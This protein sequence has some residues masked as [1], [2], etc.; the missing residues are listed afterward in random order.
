[1]KLNKAQHIHECSYEYQLTVWLDIK[2]QTHNPPYTQK[3]P[4][5]SEVGGRDYCIEGAETG[6]IVFEHEYILE[7]EQAE[8]IMNT[9]RL[10]YY[11]VTAIKVIFYILVVLIHT[12]LLLLFGGG[13][14]FL[15][16]LVRFSF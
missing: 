15:L 6:Q 3:L 2:Y 5:D 12:F 16:F 4:T 10:I 9:T 7:H 8:A 14:E 1:M 13:V 11:D